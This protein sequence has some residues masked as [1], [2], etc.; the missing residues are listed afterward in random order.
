MD[1]EAHWDCLNLPLL[2]SVK[3]PWA[4][5]LSNIKTDLMRVTSK[6]SNFLK[7][8]GSPLSLGKMAHA[9]AKAA[10]QIWVREL[11]NQWWTKKA[12]EIQ[13]LADSG[14][15]R[16]FFNATKVAY[17]PS[18][19]FV[20]PLHFRDGQTLLNDNDSMA[21][22]LKEHYEDLLNRDHS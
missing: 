12:Q 5:R 7:S 10:I 9:K 8:S 19:R 17:N 20:T 18:Y 2:T 14:D 16:G 6:Y 11:K 3:A 1:I 22:S 15:T 4:T 21:N 13:Q